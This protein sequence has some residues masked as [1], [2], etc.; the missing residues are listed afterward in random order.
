MN[1]WACIDRSDVQR[2]STSMAAPFCGSG[3]LALAT[4]V[5]PPS[6]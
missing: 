3:P 5:A 4:G 6:P 2:S 1:N